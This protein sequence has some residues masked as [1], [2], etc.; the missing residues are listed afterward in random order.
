MWHVIGISAELVVEG[1]DDARGVGPFR[2]R[3]VAVAVEGGAAA[4]APD[5]WETWLLVVDDTKPG[6]VWVAQGD[7]ASQRLGR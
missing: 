3:V 5:T 4:Q 2:G 1:R 7:V 6:P